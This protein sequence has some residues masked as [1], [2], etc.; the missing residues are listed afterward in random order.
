MANNLE[1][2]LMVTVRSEQPCRKD[3]DFTVSA[4]ALARESQAALRDF[5][6][7]VNIPG[8]RKG[9]APAAMLKARYAEDIASELKRRILYAAFDKVN[10]DETLDIVSCNLADDPELKDGEEFKFTLNVDVAPEFETGDYKA[11]KV[12]VPAAEVTDDQVA[13]RVNFYRTMY[14]G[15]ADV[16]DAAKA[17]DMLKVDY[18]SDFVP[19]EDASVSLKRQAAA[20]GSYL[21]LSDPEIIP[22]ATAALTGATAGQE[23]EFESTYAEDYREAALAGKTLKYKVKVLAIQR[24]KDLT[25]EEL[26]EK[27]RVKTLDEF[28]QMLRAS[29][30]NEAKAKQHNE[31]VDKVY[32]TLD[33]Q[34]AA[35]DLP[36]AVLEGE[37]SK[38]MRKLANE[39]V[40]S[41]A[42]VEDFK[43]K[44]EEHRKTAEENAKKSLRRTFILRKIAKAEQIAISQ[45]ELNVQLKGLSQYYG[46]KEKELRS[47][48]EK[49]GGM[50]ELQLDILNAKV[51]EFLAKQAEENAA[52]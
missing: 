40:K 45:D 17:E 10:A 36:P 15:Y 34:I 48:L 6:Q 22:G 37:I 47:M 20:E 19:A 2:A 33:E 43:A 39:L 26:C 25:D 1:N 5:A 46:Y 24:K 44:S 41:E 28:Q 4:D 9:K 21:W 13:E 50:D 38:E 51:L 42:D 35:F 12:D 32:Q 3:Y 29:L 23:I 14:A 27:A 8:F 30:E 49:S 16:E 18:S 11:L 52:K 7:Y 31:L